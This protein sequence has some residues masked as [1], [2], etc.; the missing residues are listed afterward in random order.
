MSLEPRIKVW[1]S[2]GCEISPKQSIQI[3]SISGFSLFLQIWVKS[4]MISAFIMKH[5]YMNL[6]LKQPAHAANI[7]RIVYQVPRKACK[8]IA[9]TVKQCIDRLV[10]YS[11][12][13][14]CTFMGR[15]T[16]STKDDKCNLLLIFAVL[17]HCL[18]FDNRTDFRCEH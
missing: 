4:K 5:A 13:F 2:P 6:S 9:I 1:G 15:A 14:Q 12:K 18:E 16:P 11:K 17:F 3:T 10:V 8:R 7:A